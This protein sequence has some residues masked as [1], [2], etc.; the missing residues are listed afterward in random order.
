MSES[1]SVELECDGRFPSGEWTGFFLQSPSTSRHWM[2]LRLTFAGGSLRGEGSDLVG[3]F[4]MDGNYKLQDGR[5]WWTKR[6]TGRHDV[7]YSGYNEGKGIWGVW[8]IPPLSKGGFHIWPA[9][10]ADPTQNALTQ[11]EQ[12]PVGAVGTRTLTRR[13]FIGR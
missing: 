3:P 12:Q 10:M 9:G 7:S 8:E 11:T 1:A 2:Q 6:Y 5:C 4:T 13:T